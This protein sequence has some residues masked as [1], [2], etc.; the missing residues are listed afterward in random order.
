MKSQAKDRSLQIRS[1]VSNNRIE[2]FKLPGKQVAVNC[3]QL[4]PENQPQWHKKMDTHMVHY[5]HY[6]FQKQYKNTQIGICPPARYLT[7]RF[8][9]LYQLH[10]KQAFSTFHLPPSQS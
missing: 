9:F 1:L 4:Y 3:H 8:R 6:V 10:D 5:V 2:N 7:V